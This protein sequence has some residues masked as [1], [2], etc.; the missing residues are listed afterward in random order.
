MT[1]SYKSNTSSCLNLINFLVIT[2][3]IVLNLKKCYAKQTIDHY[4]ESGPNNI[5]INSTNYTVKVILLKPSPKLLYINETFSNETNYNFQLFTSTTSGTNLNNSFVNISNLTNIVNSTNSSFP[6]KPP[7]SLPTATTS[8]PTTTTTIPQPNSLQRRVCYFANWA[9]Y[10]DLNP[11][12]YPD[13]IDPSLCTH[14]HYAFAKIDPTTLALVPTEEHDMNWTEKSNMPLYIR[15]YGLKRRNMALKIL[16]AVGGWS[17]KSLGFNLAT[18]NAQNRSRFI[19]QT[20][21]LLREWNFDG[22]DLD[23][24][25]PGDRERDAD[26]RSK[27]NFNALVTE[28]RIAVNAEAEASGK[29]KLLITS[30]V[31]AD[32]KKINN[33][34]V[35]SNLCKQLDYVCFLKNFMQLLDD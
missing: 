4:D 34:Y 32:P 31:A 7:P 9:L 13:N 35:V 24:E 12:L 29:R 21:R 2:L 1:I 16:L 33:G 20:I 17:A 10:R 28:F 14:I 15:L 27:E 5:T 6:N 26:V 23:W 19:N 8:L 11:P 25:F 18:R 22:V 30:A 3:T